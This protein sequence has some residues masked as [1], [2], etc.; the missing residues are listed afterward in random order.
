MLYCNGIRCEVAAGAAGEEK[1]VRLPLQ[2]GVNHLL[3]KVFNKEDR[4]WD[5]TF[6]LQDNI[7]VSNHK[8]KYQLNA[9]SN[10]YE[11]D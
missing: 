1:L 4:P 6:R 11:V 10:V 5:F 7:A 8:H 3:L 2:A 9:K